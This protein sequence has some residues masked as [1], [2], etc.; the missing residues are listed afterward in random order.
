MRYRIRPGPGGLANNLAKPKIN[1]TT[2]ESAPPRLLGVRVYTSI[3]ITTGGS[4]PPRLLGPAT[5]SRK[6][7]I[8]VLALKAIQT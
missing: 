4:G 2:G 5:I 6:I 7:K 3:N 1:I 8:Q